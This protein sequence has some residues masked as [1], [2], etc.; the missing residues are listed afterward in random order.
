MEDRGWKIEDGKIEDR[1]WKIEDRGWKIDP[2]A[3]RT[4]KSSKG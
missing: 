3:L 1:G 4:T 2:W